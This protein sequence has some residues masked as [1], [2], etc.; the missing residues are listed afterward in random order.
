MNTSFAIDDL[1]RLDSGAQ[2]KQYNRTFR[3]LYDLDNP[4]S[5]SYRRWKK[6]ISHRTSA[7]PSVIGDTYG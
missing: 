2:A 6:T 5:N 4:R 7:E 1:A 3:M